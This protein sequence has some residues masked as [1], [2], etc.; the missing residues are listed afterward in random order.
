[1]IRTK[2]FLVQHLDMTS[3]PSG[4]N[5]TKQCDDPAEAFASCEEVWSPD[6]SPARQEIL[7]GETRERW[8]R[9]DGAADWQHYGPPR[10]LM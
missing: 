4:A 7:D 1:M 2:R 10:D 8:F 5:W 6:A 9:A 3:G